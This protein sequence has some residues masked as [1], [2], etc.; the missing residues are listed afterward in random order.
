MKHSFWGYFVIVMGIAIIVIMLLI[1]R[2]T[3]T[4]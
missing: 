1:Q 3:T 2:M 4:T